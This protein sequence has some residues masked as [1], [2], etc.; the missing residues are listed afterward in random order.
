[1]A[2]PG[3]QSGGPLARGLMSRWKRVVARTV[4]EC[5]SVGVALQGSRPG[6]RILLYHAVGSSVAA[7][8][9]GFSVLP[10]RFAQQMDLLSHRPDVEIVDLAGGLRSR[11]RLRVAVTFDDGYKD[12][13]TTAAPTL[14]QYRIPFTV[15]ATS[16]LLGSSSDYLMPAE[17]RELAGLPGVTIGSHGLTHTPLGECGDTVLRRELEESR[18]RL[19]ELLGRPVIAVAYP[20]GSVDQRVRREAARAGYRLGACS[21]STIN[22]AD[23][24]PLLLCRTEII[25]A[26]STRVFAQKLDG[27]WDW[28]RW[29]SP[30]PALIEQVN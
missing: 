25:G 29:R 9:Y 5:R 15:F 30:D 3:N 10:G 1:M 21:R 7:D 22:A 16:A 17:L 23:R 20:H 8:S 12:I 4:S 19:E 24:D 2:A 26:D 13:L 27:A 14:L 11:G 28:I 18:R 6:F